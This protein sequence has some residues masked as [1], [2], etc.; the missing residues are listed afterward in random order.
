MVLTLLSS[1]PEK[2]DKIFVY[3]IIPVLIIKYFQGRFQEILCF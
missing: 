3:L 2:G 1:L